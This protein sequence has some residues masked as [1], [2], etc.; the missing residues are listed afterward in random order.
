MKCFC[1][2]ACCLFYCSLPRWF[3]W[4]MYFGKVINGLNF[5]DWNCGW[6]F[7]LAT[8]VVKVAVI[9][10]LA[11]FFP[12]SVLIWLEIITSEAFLFN[13][14][15]DLVLS[16]FILNYS[17]VIKSRSHEKHVKLCSNFSSLL[18]HDTNSL[19]QRILYHFPA[20]KLSLPS[21]RVVLFFLFFKKIY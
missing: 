11:T 19:F 7:V 3:S 1:F 20:S 8:V 2:S 13:C 18:S 14:L 12:L 5:T 21:L 9:A 16:L 10:V 17:W 6:T 4:G 15:H